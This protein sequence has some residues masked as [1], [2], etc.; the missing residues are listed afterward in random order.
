MENNSLVNLTLNPG[1]MMVQLILETI[2]W[3]MKGKKIISMDS[4]RGGHP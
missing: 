1:N 4:S 2:T 3:H